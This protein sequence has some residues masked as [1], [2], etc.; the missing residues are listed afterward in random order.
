[1]ELGRVAAK[2]RDVDDL[3]TFYGVTDED[4]RERLIELVSQSAAP[5]WWRQYADVLP[6]WFERYIGLE[7]GA[8]EIRGYQVQFVP[9]LLQTRD[10][11]RSV[12]RRPVQHPPF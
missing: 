5:G 3:L 9:G 7:R 11:A 8:A 10:Y 12:V 6:D 2:Q 1:M 4:E